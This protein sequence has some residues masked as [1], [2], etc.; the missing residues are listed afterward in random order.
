MCWIKLIDAK[1]SKLDYAVAYLSVPLPWV[2]VSDT[3]WSD[4]YDKVNWIWKWKSHSACDKMVYPLQCC[5]N[6]Q[7]TEKRCK[8]NKLH[9]NIINEN[10]NTR[11]TK[12]S[13]RVRKYDKLKPWIGF[14]PLDSSEINKHSK[15][16]EIPPIAGLWGMNNLAYNPLHVIS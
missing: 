3:C 2:S 1:D 7:T 12:V 16:L 8:R 4:C 10:K 15:V 13:F 9:I 5:R 14:T 11:V 6:W